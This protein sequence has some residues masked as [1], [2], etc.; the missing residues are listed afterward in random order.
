MTIKPITSYKGFDRQLRCRGHQFEVGKTYTHT[1]PVEICKSGFHA[2]QYPLAV[3]GYYPPL[4]SRYAVV[5]QMGDLAQRVDD[6]KIASSIIAITAELTLQELIQAAV[7]HTFSRA[8]KVK[9]TSSATNGDRAN[10]ATDGADANS[11]TNGADAHSATN[12]AR[13]HSATNGVYSNSA[14]NGADAHSA[15]NG[16]G[17]HSATNGVY[18]NSATNGDDAHSATNGNDA[19]SAT[20][21][22]CAN[23]ATNGAR[24]HSAT[25]GERAH[26]ATNGECAHSATNGARANSATTGARANSEAKGAHSVAASLGNGAACAAE[27]GA[28]FL[29]ERNALYEIVAVFASKI[30]EHGIKAHTWYVLRDGKPVEVTP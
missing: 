20:N 30:G 4:S 2:C 3:F 26:S 21:G 7:E 27:T 29:V 5:T 23:S 9:S 12:G 8:K 16:Y 13:A 22:E 6:S 17:A 19:N 18:S 25:N 24:A 28:I 10:S 15:T 11:A 1:G 14:T